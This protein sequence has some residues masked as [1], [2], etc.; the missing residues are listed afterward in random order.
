VKL[1]PLFDYSVLEIKQRS[2][3][4]EKYRITL[5]KEERRELES[6]VGKGKAAARKLAHARILLLADDSQSNVLD[7]DAIASTLSLG[8]RT[9]SRVRKRFVTEGF[10][11]A[12]DH[13]PQPPR[14][15]KIKIKG[16]IEQEL[17]RIACTD[18]PQGRAHWTLQ[19]LAD[20]LIALGLTKSVSTETVRQ[21]LKKTTS[22][23]GSSARGVF[24]P[25]LTGSMS[26]G[27]RM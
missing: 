19:L 26:G 6:L 23:R 4:M 25:R 11:A 10:V 12:L 16:D 1:Y 5:S 3:A 2:D 18:P 24:R 9:V 15:D 8:L 22:I 21:A 14:P 7:D 27:W 20:E 17:I 13:K